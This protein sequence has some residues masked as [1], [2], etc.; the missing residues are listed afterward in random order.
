MKRVIIVAAIALFVFTSCKKDETKTDPIP[1]ETVLDYFP[2]AIGNYWVYEKSG[3]DSTWIDCNSISFDTNFVTKDTM[4]NGLK[5][6]KIEG[7][8]LIGHKAQFIRDSLD[9]IV[10]EK[11]NIIFSNTDFTSI[12]YEQYIVPNNDTLYHWYRKMD[13]TPI[14]FNVPLGS[15]TCLDNKLSLFRKQD[16]FEKE[17]N[18]HSAYSK[19][20][21]LIY[22]SAMYAGSTGGIKREIVSHEKL[23]TN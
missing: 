20:V 6:Y 17:Y 14:V 15:F 11:G 12:L 13:E 18:T 21:G 5:Y 3:C 8:N 4:L 16:N 23:I 9:Y 1:Q 10:D 2:L 7:E 22:E 19:G